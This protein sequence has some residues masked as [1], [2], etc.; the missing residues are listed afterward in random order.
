MDW[1]Q[2]FNT[3]EAVLWTLI[4]LEWLR[5]SWFVRSVSLQTGTLTGLTFLAF[6]ASDVVEVFTG[7]FWRPWWLLVWKGV[8]IAILGT[9]WLRQRNRP[10]RQSNPGVSSDSHANFPD[11]APA[12]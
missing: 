9:L 10:H 11:R 2:I 4:G 8:C 1:L 6:G 7:A 5:R 12:D 3:V